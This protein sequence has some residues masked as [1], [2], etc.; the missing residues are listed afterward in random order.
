MGIFYKQISF[1]T[2]LESRM[3][4]ELEQVINQFDFVIKDYIVNKQLFREGEDGKG[5]VLPG[6]TRTT[7]R[8]KIAKGDPAD[9]TTLRDDGD[10]YS[11]IE[12]N[13][14]PEHFE[15]NSN[16]SHDVYLVKKYGQDIL[17]VSDEHL[18]EFLKHYYLPKLKEYA[19]NQLTK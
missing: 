3:F 6:Y 8:Y 13:A 16:V 18:R 12:V 7:I 4:T 2:E 11:H 1:L 10:F 9:R 15:I 14:F 19:T 17:R 5:K